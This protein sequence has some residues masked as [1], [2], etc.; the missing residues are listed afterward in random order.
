MPAVIVGH[1]KCQGNRGCENAARYISADEQYL[2]GLCAE[3][4]QARC[5]RVSDVPELLREIEHA[6]L[7]FQRARSASTTADDGN[8][9]ATRGFNAIRKVLGWPTI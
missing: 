2:C 3:R 9:E 4:S 7:N 5:V 1:F 6:S 8:K